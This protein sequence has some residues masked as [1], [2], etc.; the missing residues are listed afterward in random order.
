VAAATEQSKKLQRD[1]HNLQEQLDSASAAK[2]R[3]E[4]LRDKLQRE[5]D[6][7]NVQLNSERQQ[8]SQLQAKQKI[9]DKQMSELRTQLEQSGTE[10]EK[11]QTS[12]RDAQTKL[13]VSSNELADLKDRVET[14]DLAKKRL[15]AELEE[16]ITNGG[17]NSADLER[18]RRELQ[19]QVDD[20]KQQ[21][22]ELEDELQ[23][24]N[25]KAMH[26]EVA[27]AKF[28][29]ENR[30]LAE[31]VANA[32]NSEALEGKV[33]ALQ[34]RVTEL[35]EDADNERRLRGKLSN[36]KRKLDLD[37]ATLQGRVDDMNKQLEREQH[38]R[39]KAEDQLNQLIGGVA[40]SALAGS[41]GRELERYKARAKK[42]QG[43]IDDLET[44]LAT[45]E[46]AKRRADRELDDN[47]ELVTTYER[48]ITNLRE[49]IRRIL[50][51]LNSGDRGQVHM[52][53]TSTSTVRQGA[54]T[55]SHTETGTG[56]PPGLGK[57]D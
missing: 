15:E 57:T 3:A 37:M 55:V 9:H 5:L 14:T 20:Q 31:L 24:T 28:K 44:K 1:I 36:E 30:T 50:A 42:D 27:N 7:L 29:E 41:E 52:H 43:T 51:S 32:S 54:E 6:D 8:H 22:L 48:E 13:M 40:S 17:G 45:T 33:K 46:A 4:K 19:K 49:Q 18:V 56:L 38:L 34:R 25:D 16:Y 23:L 53:W 2:S 26:A 10:L 47:R 35:T 39:K 11:T 21:I 12:L